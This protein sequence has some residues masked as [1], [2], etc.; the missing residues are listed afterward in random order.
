VTYRHLTA[1]ISQTP[2]AFLLNNDEA[3]VAAHY[4]VTQIEKDT[5]ELIPRDAS[6]LVRSVELHFEGNTLS[7]LVMWD[8]LGHVT[9]ITLHHVVV[10]H[11]IN[12]SLFL[13]TPPKNV[14]VIHE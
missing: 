3:T 6:N 14:D 5:F 8:Q 2:A 13:F 7:Q 12:N 10:N 9:T 11:A 4:K 1:D